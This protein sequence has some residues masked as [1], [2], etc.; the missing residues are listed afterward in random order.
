MGTLLTL[1][2]VPVFYTIIDDMRVWTVNF[3]GNLAGRRAD[4][5]VQ[6]GDG[7]T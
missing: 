3:L 1:I 7:G 6:E 4:A 2:I 5:P